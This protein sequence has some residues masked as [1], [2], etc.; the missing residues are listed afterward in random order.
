MGKSFF[1]RNIISLKKKSDPNRK[2][3]LTCVIL[4]LF[5]LGNSIPLGGIDQ[6]ALAKVFSQV[7][8]NNSFLQLLRMYSGSGGNNVLTP[9]SLGIIPYINASI[10]IDLLATIIPQLEKLNSEEGELGKQKLLFYKKVVTVLFA[11]VQSFSLLYY[12]KSYLYLPDFFHIGLL[13]INL[14]VGSLIIVWFTNLIDNQGLGN[15]TSIFIFINILSSSILSN[16]AWQITQQTKNFFLEIL[17]LLGISLL[18]FFSQTL[19]ISIPIISA[20]QLSFL[21]T[22]E[23]SREK[24]VKAELNIDE[25]GLLL[26]IT[27]AGIFPIIIASNV[28][29]LFAYVLNLVF[30]TPQ[31]FLNL[32]YYLL[33]I[34]FNYF[35]TILF[36]DPEKISEQLRKNAVAI[37]NIR[38]GIETVT[39]LNRVVF[40]SSIAGGIFLCFILLL[41]ESIKIFLQ[42]PFL[43]RVSVSSLIIFI[44]ILYDLQKTTIALYKVIPD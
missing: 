19:K 4:F 22:F 5:R 41:F 35:Y 21:E 23:K 34:S 24:T 18:I 2:I 37:G 43:N 7:E 10:L 15:G 38:P 8:S 25:N 9:L 28:L 39:Y 40:Y 16:N 11:T 27:Q 44:G 14:I 12:L 30:K 32:V 29:P 6:E 20:R 3:F 36:W 17:F 33:I 1:N 31:I 42:S 26:R 13:C